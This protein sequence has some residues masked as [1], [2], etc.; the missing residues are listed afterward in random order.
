RSLGQWLS[1]SGSDTGEK[2]SRKAFDGLEIPG[3]QTTVGHLVCCLG[4]DLEET[5]PCEKLEKKSLLPRYLGRIKAMLRGQ[6]G[7]CTGAELLLGIRSCQPADC[8]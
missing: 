7:L 1:S 2:L 3:Y 6:F 4:A 8:P 5:I